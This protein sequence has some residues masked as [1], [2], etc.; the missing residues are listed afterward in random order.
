MGAINGGHTWLT[1]PHIAEDLDV[2]RDL[3]LCALDA[4]LLEMLDE[5]L[6]PPATA[7][8]RIGGPRRLPVFPE[9]W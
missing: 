2:A 9:T 7:S 1:S 5:E 8:A 3:F 6:V 4:G